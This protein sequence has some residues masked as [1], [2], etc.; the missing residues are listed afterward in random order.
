MA[1]AATAVWEVRTTGNDAN[2][3]FYDSGGTDYSQQ[4]AA[5]LTLADV[6]TNGTTSVTS[7]TGGFTAAMIGN[8][9]NV[10]GAIRQISAFTSTNTITV[11][12]LISAAS[13][14]AGRVGGAL[15]TPAVATG[16][17]TGGN[18]AFIK[19]HASNVYGINQG[20]TQNTTGGPMSLNVAHATSKTRLVGYDSTRTVTST[21][22][23]RPILRTTTGGANAILVTGTSARQTEIVNL[24][25]DGNSVALS[26]AV[27]ASTTASAG[28]A[29]LRCR[30]RRMVTVVT[31]GLWTMEECQLQGNAG[32]IGGSTVVRML[33][34]VVS[35]N[36]SV[37]APLAAGVSATRCIF[38]RNTGASTD[39]VGCSANAGAGWHFDQCIF[40]GNGRHGIYCDP[41]TAAQNFSIISNCLFTNNAGWGI[42][43]V[44]SQ[45]NIRL[46]N[47]AFYNNTSGN[48]NSNIPNAVGTVTLSADPYVNRQSTVAA[49]DYGLNTTAGGGAACR[50]AGFPGLLTATL[51]TSY[52]DIGV[53]QHVDAGG[54]TGVKKIR[55]QIG[56]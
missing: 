17:M 56:Q 28:I 10:A 50:A 2:G 5:Q 29:L 54:T 22:A 33:G 27:A 25:L 42:T 41:A 49:S 55:I 48:V 52:A 40:D 45:D 12:A 11:D 31:S 39:G 16:F 47:C 9:I 43:A 19:Y 35:E 53:A 44:V 3:G 15:A 1:I 4:D 34:C 20:S 18:T 6:V 13:G 46:R 51:T 30:L 36:T 38:A 24:D 32:S 7:A 23:N 37:F 8:G 26:R 14:Q 21:D